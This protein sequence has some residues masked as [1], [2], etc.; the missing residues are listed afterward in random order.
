MVKGK[1]P[2]RMILFL[3]AGIWYNRRVPVRPFAPPL[4][5]PWLK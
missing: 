4:H 3:V 5:P 1:I 2:D